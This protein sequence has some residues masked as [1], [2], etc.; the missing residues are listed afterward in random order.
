MGLRRLRTSHPT[1]MSQ[2]PEFPRSHRGTD[3]GAGRYLAATR[4]RGAGRASFLPHACLPQRSGQPVETR[5]GLV[6]LPILASVAA[7]PMT[8][9][10]VRLDDD[11][12]PEAEVD[13]R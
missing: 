9:D 5:A 12:S 13:T 2:N 6:T 10:T 7:T 3:A 1:T 11:G 4:Q 8:G